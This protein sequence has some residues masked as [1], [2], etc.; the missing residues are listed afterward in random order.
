MA[1]ARGRGRGRGGGPRS[2]SQQYLQNSANE[3]GLDIKNV[4]RSAAVGIFPDLELHSNGERRLLEHESDLLKEKRDGKSVGGSSS[5]E[6]VANNG[7]D[8]TKVK[9]E[10][11]TSTTSSTTTQ[12]D[13]SS[14][15]KPKSPKTIYLISKSREMNHKFQNSVFYIRGSTKEV[16]D[17]ERF[18]DR[19]REYF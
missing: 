5:T 3:A 11:N 18:S 1:G 14:S 9:Q 6:A 16:P 4:G 7:E 12:D 15:N 19:F 13:T 10:A 17:V 8:N 2:V